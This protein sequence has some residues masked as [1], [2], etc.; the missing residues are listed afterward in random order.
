MANN[1]W[2]DYQGEIWKNVA[3]MHVIDQVA[4]QRDAWQSAHEE[5]RQKYNRLIDKFNDLNDHLKVV[6][7]ANN[8][9]FHQ[10]Q[11]LDL[12]IM[13]LT[14]TGAAA[15][16]TMDD[17]TWEAVNQA[18]ETARSGNSE[19]AVQEAVEDVK[20][21][22]HDIAK[23]VQICDFLQNEFRILR[24][25]DQM[26]KYFQ[27]RTALWNG[28]ENPLPVPDSEK[29]REYVRKVMQEAFLRTNQ[30]LQ[31][32]FAMTV[33][34]KYLDTQAA[35]SSG[36]FAAPS[37]GG[38][39]APSS[40]GGFAGP[41]DGDWP[42]TR[43]SMVSIPVFDMQAA[44]SSGVWLAT[45]S[46]GDDDFFHFNQ[47]IE[48]ELLLSPWNMV[49]PDVKL[50]E[51]AQAMSAGL[52][53]RILKRMRELL[54]SDQQLS[55]KVRETEAREKQLSAKVRETETQNR[56]LSA[57]V[58]EVE[59]RDRQ[60]LG[61]SEQQQAKIAELENKIE[62]KSVEYED[63]ARK[64]NRR[65]S[66]ERDYLIQKNDAL[67]DEAGEQFSQMQEELNQ[68]KKQLAE[69]FNA[70]APRIKEVQPTTE[71]SRLQDC[72]PQDR[73]PFTG[74]GFAPNPPGQQGDVPKPKSTGSKPEDGKG[75]GW[76]GPN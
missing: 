20:S 59:S 42:A 36:G 54:Q 39:A 13:I 75:G 18:Y 43:S 64:R 34:G 68:L 76:S 14:N 61:D 41:S 62:E 28:V 15:A 1:Y 25:D 45:S 63:R 24:C 58:Q 2:N 53:K 22:S 10:G 60:R 16:G 31:D 74:T 6:S 21:F 73:S 57:K 9:H 7:K 52:E 37:S 5:L 50:A 26:G 8:E 72:R 67:L 47:Y 4:Y 44:C 11:R 49:T 23:A 30:L 69:A 48:R 70:P 19:D 35:G 65:A 32:R 40:G 27:K 56:Q 51:K 46:G 33:L 29:R 38:F 12:E 71:N 3:N 17:I 55:A 66:V